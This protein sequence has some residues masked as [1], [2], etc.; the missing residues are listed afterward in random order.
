MAAKTK[1]FDCVEMKRRAQERIRAEW[2]RRKG[3][4]SS[5]GEFLETSL[6]ESEWGREIWRKFGS[7]KSRGS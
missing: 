1:R 5:Y 2:E 4:F 3:A 6:N 7:R